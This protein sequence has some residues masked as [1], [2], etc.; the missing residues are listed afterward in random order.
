LRLGRTKKCN[1]AALLAVV[2]ILTVGQS[3]AGR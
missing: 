3:C 2:V 1:L